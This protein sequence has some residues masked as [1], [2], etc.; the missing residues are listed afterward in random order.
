MR[1][2]YDPL[3]HLMMSYFIDSLHFVIVWYIYMYLFDDINKIYLFLTEDQRHRRHPSQGG[4]RRY[5]N[6]KQVTG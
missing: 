3:C 6:H 4:T 5:G 1:K 2:I